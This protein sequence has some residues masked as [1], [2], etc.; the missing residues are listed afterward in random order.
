MLSSHTAAQ[1]IYDLA[2]AHH[3]Q[4]SADIHDVSALCL[5]YHLT[6]KTEEALQTVSKTLNQTSEVLKQTLRSLFN[7]KDLEVG[8]AYFDEV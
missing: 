2:S 5:L 7:I 4:S 1:A 6:G 8:F 3:L